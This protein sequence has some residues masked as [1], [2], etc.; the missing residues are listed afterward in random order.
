MKN[1]NSSLD[2]FVP[3]RPGDKLG[4]LHLDSGRELLSEGPENKL[5]HTT[6]SDMVRALGDSDSGR[7]LG[8]SDIDESLKEIDEDTVP[9]KKL[10]RR[11][12]RKLA[13]K[14]KRPRSLK[15]RIIRWAVLAIVILLVG[16]G[17][18]I[19]YK[20]FN[21]SGNILQGSIF[22][23]FS[24][25]PLKQDSNGRSNFLILGTAEDDPAH[26]RNGDGGLTDSI[27]V[28][29]VDQNNKNAY[30]FSVPRD[31][32]VQ[33]G[34]ACNSGYSGKINE[35]FNC[36]NSGTTKDAEQD[37][38]AKT[39]KFV[40]DIFG[41]DIQYGIH[42]NYTVMRDVI[43]AIGGKITITIESR[44]PR[45]Q[46]DSNFDWKCGASYY[47]RI[48]NCP[49]NGHYIDYP[50]GPVTLD[51]EHALYLAQARGDISPTYGLEM[52]NPD[53]E[54]NQQKILIAIRDKALSTGTLTNLGSISNLI[55]ALGNNLRTNIQTDEIRTL[56]Q[57]AGEIKSN[58]IRTLSLEG[59]GTDATTAYTVN[60]KIGGADV[61]V[62][63]AGM[64]NYNDIKAFIN[65]NL[66][67]NPVIREAA[68]IAVFNGSN[69]TGLCQSETDKLTSAHYN[70]TCIGNA[71]SGKY[72]NVEVYQI[73]NGNSGTADALAK[74]YNI[75]IKKT[76][77]PMSVSSD[78]RFVIIF[79]S[80]SS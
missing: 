41:I 45:G 70:A 10:S 42:V 66:S 37:R 11:Q 48:K 22:D 23:I 52:S 18:Y 4:D 68:P 53:R 63:A 72:G 57:V 25:K 47:D 56:V 24:S 77:P 29:S 20:F 28:L 71:P 34:M 2:G 1:K 75:T 8:R 3:R 26:I 32:Y 49:P 54:K 9:E 76:A 67:N 62:S 31:L 55:D 5:L 19:G 60:S 38:L 36:A 46:M 40:G 44:D 51:A 13:K 27:L 64:Y 74:L 12:R 21:A 58:D 6:G 30:M 69:T 7:G 33:F 78:V 16:V 59:D 65:K 43:N 17:G 35:Y 15:S 50:I 14:L 39:Q 80:A 61:V 79:G 73:G